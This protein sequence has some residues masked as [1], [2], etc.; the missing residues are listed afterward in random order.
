MAVDRARF[1][2]M[3]A[4]AQGRE[5]P[6][7]TDALTRSVLSLFSVMGLDPDLFRAALE[8]IATI[9]PVQEIVGRADVADRIRTTREAMKGA[10][11]VAPPGPERQQLLELL[12]A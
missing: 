4:A 5:R 10:R 8:Y 11:P 7:P 2:E 1:A 3:E 6:V 9:T 12:R